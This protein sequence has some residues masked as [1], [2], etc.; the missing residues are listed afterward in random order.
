MSANDPKQTF[1]VHASRHARQDAW[2]PHKGNRARGKKDF[3]FHGLD[4]DN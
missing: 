1:R 3:D 2:P 4:Y